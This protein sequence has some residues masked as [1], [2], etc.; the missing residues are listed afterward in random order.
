MCLHMCIMSVHAHNHMYVIKS[1]KNACLLYF[2]MFITA[3]HFLTLML[4]TLFQYC[5]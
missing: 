4:L 3:L 1:F 2:I 5:G